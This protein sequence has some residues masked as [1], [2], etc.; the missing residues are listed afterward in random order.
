MTAKIVELA[1]VC[2][3]LAGIALFRSLRTARAGNLTAAGAL[4]CAVA[5]IAARYSFASPVLLL[6]FVLVGASAGW[7]LARRVSMVAIP[8]MIALQNGL[9]G[10]A[11]FIVAS[12]ELIR[13][14]HSIGWHPPGVA[15]LLGIGVGAATFSG[16][17]IAA[18][19]L[20]RVLAQAP[21]RL[22]HHDRMLA[23]TAG[24]ALLLMISA[25]YGPLPIMLPLSAL[26]LILTAGALG[27]LLSMRVGGADMPVLISFLNA[28]SG[29]AAAL[30]GLS[31]GNWLLIAAGGTVGVSGMILTQ[32]MC[33]A[34]NRRLSSVLTGSVSSGLAA[35]PDRMEEATVRASS[36][37]K[38]DTQAA[39]D[40]RFAQAAALL[41][42]ARRVIIVPGY[43]MALADA[44]DEASRLA[45]ELIGMGKEIM[46][47]VHAVAG[48]MPGHM[49]V[50]LAEA[51]VDYTLIRDMNAAN[52]EFAGADVAL[53]VGACDVVNPAA[54]ERTDTPISGMPILRAHEARHIIACNLDD[55]PGYSGVENPLYRDPRTILLLGDAKETL[56]R[57]MTEMQCPSA[58]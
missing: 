16:S 47:A 30:C 13:A 46:F 58:A 55:K 44:Q 20:S 31:I 11:S 22:P 9:G 48:R 36:S 35:I 12:V 19:R 32:V 38:G 39:S 41:R 7:S 18:G 34:M 15:A 4:L 43:G 57:L 53:I 2:I 3:L 40:D 23:A 42:S 51:E 25:L 45:D 26:A 56:A 50:L 8:G 52:P 21:I 14:G 33:Q 24:A 54:V 27:V 1:I 49:H 17:L 29:V 28:G 6:C 10:L 37:A 5:V